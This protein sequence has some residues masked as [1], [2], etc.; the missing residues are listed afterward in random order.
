MKT[1]SGADWIALWHVFRPQLFEIYTVFIVPA[2]FVCSRR[3]MTQRSTLAGLILSVA[4]FIVV[5]RFPI[6]AI[7]WII[8]E[9]LTFGERGRYSF[10][11]GIGFAI[12]MALCGALAG[13]LIVRF[14]FKERIGK[15]G[16]A[17]LYV[18]NLLAA[19][20]AI[21]LVLTWA[22]IYPPQIIA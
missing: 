21:G 19:A 13:L 20:F 7:L 1:L 3:L 4:S 16:F 9:A 22:L 18:G 12:F 15:K 2:M 8:I 5:M 6:G 14:V 10:L 17:L 11:N